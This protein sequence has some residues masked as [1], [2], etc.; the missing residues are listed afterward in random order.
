MYSYRF[1]EAEAALDSAIALDP[2]H[3]VPPFV[4]VA[5][6]WLLSLTEQGFEA[7]HEALLQAVNATIPRYDAMISRFGRRADILLFLGSTY[8]LRTRVYLADKSWLAGMYSGLKGWSLIRKAHAMDST[9]TDAC[10]PI[11]VFNY[12]AGMHSAPVQLLARMFGIRP[13]RHLGIQILQRAVR[14][15][16]YAWIEAASTLSIVYLYIED[17]PEMAYQYTDLLLSHY[18]ENYYFNFLMGEELVRTHRLAEAREFMPRLK[19]LYQRSHPNQRLEWELKF[20]ALE[21][22]LAFDEGDLDKALERCGWVIDHYDMEFDW[23]LGIVHYMRGQS[24]EIRA[25]LA[26]A[27]EDYRVVA[28]LGNRT[29]LVE[30]ARTARDR[31]SRMMAKR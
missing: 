14:Q 4:A 27:R 11:G 28:G 1:H 8:G 17:D 25:D 16:P 5:N 23:H 6:Q 31:V 19:N 26:G 9:L 2:Y 20:A 7:S 18:P 21:A 30:K 15:A 13:D 10:L 12:Y 29:Y 22:A 24:R 3:P